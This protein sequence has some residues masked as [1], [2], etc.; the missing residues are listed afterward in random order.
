MHFGKSL[1]SARVTTVRSLGLPLQLPGGVVATLV[2]VVPTQYTL[3]TFSADGG[4]SDL[5]LVRSMR[6]MRKGCVEVHIVVLRIY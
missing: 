5:Q 2:G 3:F 6:S 4:S 1:V